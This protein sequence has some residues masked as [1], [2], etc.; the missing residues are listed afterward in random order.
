MDQWQKDVKE[1]LTSEEEASEEAAEAAFARVLT[2]LPAVEPGPEFVQRAVAASWAG[3]TMRPRRSTSRLL[4][5]LAAGLLLA[6]ASAFAS[7]GIALDAGSRVVAT[8][9]VF[10]SEV[11]LW[12][13][14][15]AEI[16]LDWWL[17]TAR[18]GNGV[19]S[20]AATPAGIAALGVAQ[21]VALGAF[22]L[23]RR[24]LAGDDTFRSPRAFCV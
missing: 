14:T 4:V 10:C 3:G 9:A 21:L 2:A 23:L 1:W 6:A 24:L 16:A 20:V 15:S 11:F 22:Y 18:V 7:Y 17:I 5:R 13:V 8:A 12:L 19:A